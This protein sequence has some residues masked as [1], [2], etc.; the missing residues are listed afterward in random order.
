MPISFSAYPCK[1][2]KRSTL[3]VPLLGVGGA[4]MGGWGGGRTVMLEAALGSV[5]WLLLVTPCML[6][7]V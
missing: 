2:S 5:C 4:L 3:T 6:E 1:V 7:V